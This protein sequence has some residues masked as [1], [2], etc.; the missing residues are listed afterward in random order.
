MLQRRSTPLTMLQAFD[1][2][3]LN[4]N[5]LKRA[6]STVSSQALQLSNSN[7]VRNN[8]RYFAGRVMDAV[9]G[10]VEKQIERVYLT[11]LSRWPSVEER[12]KAGEEIR[13]LT[14]HW[15][16]QLEKDV[17]AVPKEAKAQWEA[18]ATFCHAILNSAEFIYV[19]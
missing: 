7:M 3:Q 17:P 4:Q 19:D 10:D 2:P 11:A 16:D 12:E 6:H 8:A 9:G 18:L 14:R 1:A 15:L 13:E 5:C